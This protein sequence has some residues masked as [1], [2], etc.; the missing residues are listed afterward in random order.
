MTIWEFRQWVE[1]SVPMWFPL[2]AVGCLVVACWLAK[3]L[4]NGTRK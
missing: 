2:V 3:W 1:S 4:N